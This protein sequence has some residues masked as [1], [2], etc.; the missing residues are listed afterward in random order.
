MQLLT[1][2]QVAEI[3][4]IHVETL[5]AW[6]LTKRGPKWLKMGDKKNSPIRYKKEDVES[7]LAGV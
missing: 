2:K 1:P 3:L 7:F 4:N 6:R 5:G